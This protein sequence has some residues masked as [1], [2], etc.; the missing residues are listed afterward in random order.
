MR[1]VRVGAV[2]TILGLCVLMGEGN[3]QDSKKKLKTF[4]GPIEPNPVVSVSC[5]LRTTDRAQITEML[6]E[7]GDYVEEGQ[8]LVHL[9]DREAHLSF[10]QSVVSYNDQ[11]DIRSEENVVVLRDAE[12]RRTEEL[13][14]KG[15]SSRKD[16][17]LAIAQ[18]AVDVSK[19]AGLYAQK[20]AAAMTMEFQAKQLADRLVISP[21]SGVVV[22][23]Q[24]DEGE[25]AQGGAPI[26]DIVNLDKVFVRL[27]LDIEYLGKVK[28][29]DKAKVVL[30][31]APDKQYEGRVEFVSPIADAT[32]N[33]FPVRVEVKN[34]A[35]VKE[36]KKKK[37]RI[38]QLNDVQKARDGAKGAVR[39]GNPA[40]DEIVKLL[41]TQEKLTPAARL[42]LSIAVAEA[43]DERALPGIV[44]ALKNGSVQ[45]RSAAA[46]ALGGV[47]SK[48]SVELL[49]QTLKDESADVRWWAE[50][51]LGCLGRLSLDAL[52]KTVESESKDVGQGAARALA[53]IVSRTT[54]SGTI[55][56]TYWRAREA[57]ATGFAN[58]EDYLLKYQEKEVAQ[59]QYEIA[60][61][62][63]AEV[64]FPNL[65][66]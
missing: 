16:L 33:T 42:E 57:V 2:A 35:V 7:K 12:V 30:D 56:Q 20:T 24:L 19:L 11:S 27:D 60:P 66:E 47:R 14:R 32:A 58:P 4:K 6:V 51:S 25:V 62:L 21:L 39:H 10:I 3:A 36:K 55:D 22:Q 38:Y 29:G 34:P 17:E 54:M 43:G 46:R 65:A 50:N 63:Y 26:V 61:G 13:V 64:T 18:R 53:L 40:L 44:W 9:D 15:I 49:I 48:K 52:A 31:I 37:V 59:R 5:P 1:K 41:E 23:T 8:L 45:E 28:E